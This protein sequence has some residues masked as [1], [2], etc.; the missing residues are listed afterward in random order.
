M[1]ID[2]NDPIFN[3]CMS[4]SDLQFKNL[5]YRVAALCGSRAALLFS[6]LVYG[7]VFVA[8]MVMTFGARE[9]LPKVYEM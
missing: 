9:V 6:L 4:R 7:P 1:L 8:S 2:F 3:N 5:A